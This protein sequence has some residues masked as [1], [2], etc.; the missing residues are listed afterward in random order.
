MMSK[1]F[2]IHRKHVFFC[3]L[4]IDITYSILDCIRQLFRLGTNPVQIYT[5]VA[6]YLNLPVLA[7]A[8]ELME[9]SKEVNIRL[10]F[11]KKN[12]CFLTFCTCLH[13]TC[14]ATLSSRSLQKMIEERD[15]IHN[16]TFGF[17]MVVVLKE[18]N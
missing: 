13:H 1:L 17:F 8:Y 11:L 10:P 12:H 5:I 9:G 3:N 14:Y 7:E 16:Y 15:S 18:Q 2:H 4:Y 6:K